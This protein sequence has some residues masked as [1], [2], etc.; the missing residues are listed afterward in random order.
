MVDFKVKA[1][2]FNS[3]F[4]KQCSLINSD[5]SL[6]SEIIKKTGNSLY[7]VRFST[8]DMLQKINNLDFN[9]AHGHGEIN[10]RMLK[11]CGFPI[12]RTLQFI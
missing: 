1:E 10:I 2:I 5:S 8:E 4:G 11:T 9:K 6:P 3:F 12:C 7:S